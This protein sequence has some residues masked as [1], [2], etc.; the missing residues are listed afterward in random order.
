MQS[1]HLIQPEPAGPLR[2][3]V[4]NDGRDDKDWIP[5]FG[6][7]A[8]AAQISA[9]SSTQYDFRQRD[10]AMHLPKS[11]NPVCLNRSRSSED[12]GP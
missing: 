7:V 5:R 10:L 11:G 6:V 2:I 9:P 8:E 1:R 3:T 4:R 12:A